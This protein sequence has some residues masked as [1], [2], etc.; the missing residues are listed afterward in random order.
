MNGGAWLS[1]DDRAVDVHY[2]DLDDVERRCEEVE[3]GR[4][5]KQL[6]LFYTAGIPTYVVVGELAVN[7]VLAGALPRPAY[8]ALLSEAAA[9]RWH[10]DAIA[11]VAYARNALVARGE[12]TAPSPTCPG[13]SSKRPTGSWPAD[14]SGS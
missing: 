12:T 13:R 8:P 11:S 10:D 14:R 7:L 2:R 5:T 4:F 9:T 6:L 3:A 1:I